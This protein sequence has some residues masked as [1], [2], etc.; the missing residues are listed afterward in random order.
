MANNTIKSL[1]EGSRVNA[2]TYRIERVLGSGSFGITYLASTKI[3]IPGKL[4]QMKVDVK[5]AI[6]EFFMNDVN[7]RS[8]DGSTVEGSSGSVFVN[9]RKKF[10]KEAENLAKLTHP[11]IVKVSD[12]FDENDTTYY[13]MEFIEGSSLEKYIQEKRRIPEAE[14]IQIIRQVG[15]AL[16]Y[17]HSRKMLHLDIKPNNIMRTAEGKYILIDFGLSKQFNDKGEPESSTTIGLGTPG[18]AP[19]EQASFQKE[20][21]FP[22]TLDVYALGATLFKM[23][24]GQRAPEATYILNDGFPR[25]TLEKAGV[26]KQTIDVIEKA[27]APMKKNRYPNI[28]AFID[29]LQTPLSE[30]EENTLISEE[31]NVL[32]AVQNNE[33]LILLHTP[34][35][36]VKT[37]SKDT[38]FS[39]GQTDEEEIVATVVETPIEVKPVLPSDEKN[40]IK[41]EPK[42]PT[43]PA[44]VISV[45]LFIALIGS[46]IWLCIPHNSY[47]SSSDSETMVEYVYGPEAYDAAVEP[48]E[49]N[50]PIDAA[51]A[52]A[53]YDPATEADAPLEA[54][55]ASTEGW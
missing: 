18:Y 20:G 38:I 49:A 8:E 43:S 22:A 25:R 42:K 45:I 55:A 47:S 21:T 14:A 51:Y 9:Y 30:S 23:L 31:E 54:T 24:T 33:A 16:S 7:S 5:V 28:K 19:L 27:M 17:M 4:G 52:D 44:I 36:S 2:G 3:I 41:E 48:T 46:V 6:K 50:D 37:P 10:R 34:N 29:S 1:K 40:K 12:I 13:V 53:A 15:E 32:F 26:S 35:N 11:G 39:S